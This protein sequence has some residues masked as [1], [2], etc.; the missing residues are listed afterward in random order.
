MHGYVNFCGLA[1]MSH[2]FRY[3]VLLMKIILLTIGSLLVVLAVLIS[4]ENTPEAL[5]NE[6]ESPSLVT[7]P[8]HEVPS[9]PT[10]LVT[11][12]DRVPVRILIG[13]TTSSRKNETATLTLNVE[14]KFVKKED[15]PREESEPT[16]NPVPVTPKKPTVQQTDT[17]PKTPAD[18]PVPVVT[19]PKPTPTPPPAVPTK[20]SPLTWGVYTGATPGT[21]TEFESKVD[22]NPDYLAYFIHWPNDKGQLR[23][24]LKTV[25]GDKD[26]TLVIFWEAS[27]HTVGGTEQPAY[28]YRRI[29]AGDH[30]AYI[31]DFARQLK[32]YGDPIILIPF[33]ELNGNWTPWSGT[34]NGNT[35]EE[36]V[37]AY[38]YVHGFFNNV[39]NVKFGLA[40]NAQSVPNTPENAHTAYYPGD[41][42]VDYVGLDGFNMNWPWE[43]F[44][45]LFAPGLA[46][47][48]KYDKPMFIFSFG[49]AE[50]EKKAAWLEDAFTQ[51]EKYPLM[52]GFIYFNQNKE[53]NWLLWSDSETL[54]VF[55]EYVS[56]L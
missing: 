21:V 17:A 30:D 49:S 19:E 47:I 14:T 26:R 42:Y 23:P 9:L 8:Q 54:N 43:S 22:A 1:Q 18:T 38:R 15:M 33:S 7:V 44:N 24:W 32:D 16:T 11:Q 46:T 6:H 41:A 25:A 52:K 27:D 20:R 36:A 2:F 12:P 3:T 53:R 13:T 35:P 29:L 55:N 50:G 34:T 40:L 39:P 4:Q 45:T 10:P 48:S 5:Q 31:E 56:D 28:S 37:E 51:M